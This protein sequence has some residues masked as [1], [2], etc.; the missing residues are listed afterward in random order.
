MGGVRMLMEVQSLFPMSVL[1]R[2]LL[3]MYYALK[4]NKYHV[5]HSCFSF[6]IV[7]NATAPMRFKFYG[8]FLTRTCMTGGRK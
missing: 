2:N 3:Q 6:I 1:P 7:A 8:S 5:M 4:Q